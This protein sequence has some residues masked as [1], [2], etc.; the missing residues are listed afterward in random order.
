[1][2]TGFQQSLDRVRDPHVRLRIQMEEAIADA[3][4]TVCL[5]RRRKLSVYD[6]GEWVVKQSGDKAE[7]M[8]A[9]N[10]TDED[11]IKIQNVGWFHL[12]YGNDGYDVISDYSSNAICD[13]IWNTTIQPLADRMEEGKWSPHLQLLAEAERFIAG[14]EGDEMQNPLVDDLLTRLRS[15]IA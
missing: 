7:I 13:E 11:L 8:A 6:G 10:S 12:V 2:K 5:S 9:L 1:M 15:A 3:L 14:F 4:V